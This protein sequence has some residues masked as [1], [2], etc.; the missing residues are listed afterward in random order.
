MSWPAVDFDASEKVKLLLYTW[1]IATAHFRAFFCVLKILSA[2]PLLYPEAMLTQFKV[3]L[4]FKILTEL[5]HYF[6]FGG[7]VMLVL[8]VS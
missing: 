7:D 2:A 3:S 1:Y 5:W 4:I 6:L 8:K